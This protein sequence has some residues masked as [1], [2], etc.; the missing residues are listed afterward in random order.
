MLAFVSHFDIFL[1]N[2]QKQWRNMQ[3]ESTNNSAK[4]I[5]VT[6]CNCFLGYAHLP[7]IDFLIAC[8]YSWFFFIYFF[9]KLILLIIL[10]VS[11]GETTYYFPETEYMAV[12]TIEH[13]ENIFQ[14]LPE[15]I[16]IKFWGPK[17]H[18]VP[19]IITTHHS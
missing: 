19:R 18:I 9:C 17:L 11:V 14:I 16:F 1:I 8:S 7:F 2:K 5:R 4:K 6:F 12:I 10:F 13:N 15:K 3:V